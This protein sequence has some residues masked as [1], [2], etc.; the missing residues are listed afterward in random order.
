MERKQ[1]N[2]KYITRANNTEKNKEKTE[3]NVVGENSR[4]ERTELVQKWSK[5]IYDLCIKENV[6][7]RSIKSNLP[8]NKKIVIVWTET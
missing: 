4:K 5:F 6:S 7:T 3:K 2:I 8:F 1:T